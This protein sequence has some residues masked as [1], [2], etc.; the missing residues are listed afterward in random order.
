MQVSLCAAQHAKCSAVYVQM[1][2]CDPNSTHCLTSSAAL[3]LQASS[4]RS[5]AADSAATL[6]LMAAWSAS[7]QLFTA[8]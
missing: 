7:L 4:P 1:Q 6:R 5:L 8:L 3:S 2:S